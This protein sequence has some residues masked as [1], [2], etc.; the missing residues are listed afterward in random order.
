MRGDIPFG[1]GHIHH[2][3]TNPLYAGRIRHRKETHE[4]R[5]AAIIAPQTWDEVQAQLQAEAARPRRARGSRPDG[6]VSLLAGKLFDETGDR[7]TPSHAK[8]RK[9]KCLRYYVSLR[10]IRKSGEKGIT[11]WRLPAAE[12]E[13]RVADVV[14]AHLRAPGSAGRLVTEATA[15]DLISASERLSSKLGAEGLGGDPRGLLAPVERI[16]IV[17]GRMTIRLSAQGIAALLEVNPDRLEA[18]GLTLRLPFQSR[19]RG[20]ETR[21]ILGNTAAPEVDRTL[22]AN[23]ARARA[24][25]E[26][27]ASGQSYDAIARAEGVSKDRVMKLI[28]LAFLSPRIVGQVIAGTQPAG[29]TT[30]R[31][32]R[33]GFPSDWDEQERHFARLS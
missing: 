14:E 18:D 8:T 10:L 29:L 4:G 1:R 12:L 23:I 2:I 31:L 11:G 30:E 27:L 26:R 6:R 3:L 24:W 25:F 7:L 19:K 22:L 13:R 28:D 33:Q 16:D 20:V 32:I 21:L 17:P 5:H 15:D 9:G